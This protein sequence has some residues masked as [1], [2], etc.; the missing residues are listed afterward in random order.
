MAGA[1]VIPDSVRN[2]DAHAF[3]K[4]DR[5]T[6]LTIGSNVSFIS[7]GAFSCCTGLTGSI[8]IPDSVTTLSNE[9]FYKCS[10]VTA[11]TL[12]S[13]VSSIDG[14]TFKNCSNLASINIPASIRSIASGAFEGC[15]ALSSAVFAS[16]YWQVSG[17]VMYTAGLGSGLSL[18]KDITENITL[19]LADTATNAMYLRNTYV[20]CRWTRM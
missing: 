8:V 9:A 16:G 4:C 13:R 11:V 17:Y 18:P 7:S 2:I 3:Y 5:L 12:G 1:L 14:S 20:M 19:D 6:S 15:D 10:N